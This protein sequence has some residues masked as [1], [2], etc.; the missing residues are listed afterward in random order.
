VPNFKGKITGFVVGDALEVYRTITKIPEGE[1]VAKA[2]LTVKLAVA[3]D[4]SEALFQKVITTTLDTVEGVIEDDGSSGTAIIRFFL[5]SDDTSTL[6]NP[7]RDAG[8]FVYDI[9]IKTSSGLL[10]T[11]EIGKIKAK[12]Q[13][14][15]ATS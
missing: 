11:P 8:N 5:N 15:L 2:W 9:Q 13:V 1:T 14:T 4:D 7:E 12:P 10:F 6:G 3:D